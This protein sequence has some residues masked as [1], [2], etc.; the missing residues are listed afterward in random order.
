MYSLK[1]DIRKN[2]GIHTIQLTEHM[3]LKKEDQSVGVSVLLRIGNKII[4][5]GRERDGVG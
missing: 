5:E 3:H 4:R 1:V 2:L